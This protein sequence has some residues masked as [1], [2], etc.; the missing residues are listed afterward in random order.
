[1][2][3]GNIFMSRHAAAAVMVCA[4][5]PFAALTGNAIMVMP[6]RKENGP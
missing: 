5:R 4:V 2:A 1:M 3:Y 6:T